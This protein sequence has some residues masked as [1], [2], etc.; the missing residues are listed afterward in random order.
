M[1]EHLPKDETACLRGMRLLS[2]AV[3]DLR[4]MRF[5]RYEAHSADT[6]SKMRPLPHPYYYLATSSFLC[7]FFDLIHFRDCS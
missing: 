7:T 5:P 3:E 4:G 6:Q 2:R 1:K